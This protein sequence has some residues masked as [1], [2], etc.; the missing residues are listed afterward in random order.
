MKRF[1]SLRPVTDRVAVAILLAMTLVFASPTHAAA[2]ALPAPTGKVL[3][4]INGNIDVRNVGDTAQFGRA[5]LEAIGM[6]RL[7]TMTPWEEGAVHFEGPL[8]AAVLEKVGAKGETLTLQAIDGYQ[9]DIPMSDIR[10][11]GILLAMKRDGKW[12][13]IRDKGPIWVI[14]PLVT[15]PE[16]KNEIYSARSIWQLDR[17]TV[18]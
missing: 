4:T 8:F 2:E 7:D 15:H 17:V 9:I 3:L 6:T 13:K 12:M 1:L 10:Q 14:Y 18:K 16:L 11:Y 5:M